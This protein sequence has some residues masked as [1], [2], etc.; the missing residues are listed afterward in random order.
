LPCGDGTFPTAGVIRDAAGNLYGTTYTGGNLSSCEGGCGT[1]F[2]VDASGK[3]TVLHSF[4]GG[5]DGLGPYGGLIRDGAGNLYGTTQAGG[6][7]SY[8]TVFKLDAA[9]KL[10]VL[11]SFNVEE[12]CY[13]SA[14]LFRD[15]AGNLYGTTSS[16]GEFGS[17]T[18]WVTRCRSTQGRSH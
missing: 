1:I 10:T 7:N 9:N 12:G 8:G 5:A 14:S 11:H 13:S 17:G 16:C 3:E 15:P 6:A 4:T 18:K 2:K